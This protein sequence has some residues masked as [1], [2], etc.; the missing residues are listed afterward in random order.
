VN[1]FHPVVVIKHVEKFWVHDAKMQ[2]IQSKRKKEANCGLEK[3]K[4]LKRT[5]EKRT[6]TC[7]S[8]PTWGPQP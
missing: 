2:Q 6:Q 1:A 8:T 7:L 4:K 3:K 5:E